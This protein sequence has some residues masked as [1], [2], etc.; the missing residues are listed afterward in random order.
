M[1]ATDLVDAHDRTAAGLLV[2]TLYC[3]GCDEYSGGGFCRRCESGQSDFISP[4]GI[5]VAI[6]CG[7]GQGCEVVTP[8]A[9]RNADEARALRQEALL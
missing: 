2:A 1:P 9:G 5:G 4:S 6:V 3:P 8:P 7:G